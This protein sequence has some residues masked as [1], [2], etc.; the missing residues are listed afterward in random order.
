MS[1]QKNYPRLLARAS[2]V[3]IEIC[4][5]VLVQINLT[6]EDKIEKVKYYHEKGND[7]CGNENV[8][9]RHFRECVEPL[10]H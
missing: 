9:E 2:V 1:E 7:S 10:W 8:F 3:A 5:E 6:R 4:E